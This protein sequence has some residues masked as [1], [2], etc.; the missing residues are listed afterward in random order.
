M[1]ENGEKKLGIR[2]PVS[3]GSRIQQ[4]YGGLYDA[5]KRAKMYDQMKH[6]M[7][8]RKFL[9]NTF[10]IFILLGTLFAFW[11][12]YKAWDAHLEHKRELAAAEQAANDA[13]EAENARLRREEQERERARVEAE[14]AAQREE[15]ERK[16]QERRLA[17][18][19]RRETI[20]SYKVFSY[21][22]R[23][24]E[25][26]MYAKSVTNI[27]SEAKGELCY[28]L[29]DKEPV[30]YWATSNTNGETM[31]LRINE[32]GDREPLDASSFFARVSKFDYLVAG[33]GKVYYH[34]NRKNPVWGHLSKTQ[35]R[36]PAKVFFAGLS[37]RLET[38]KPAYDE[39]TF[40]IVFI[41][42][43]SKKQIVCETLEFGCAYSLDNVREAVVQAFPPRGYVGSSF[44]VKKFKRTAKLWDGPDIKQGVDGITYVPRTMPST[45]YDSFYSDHVL[46]SRVIHRRYARRQLSVDRWQ[47][48]YD[49][50]VKE[51]EAEAEY[52]RRQKEDFDSR[53]Q[54]SLSD[55]ERAYV[56]RIDR[57]IDEG[58]LYYHAKKRKAK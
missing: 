13:R 18:Q 3:Q 25:L 57:I 44:N 19:E 38:L 34:A 29:P 52:Y 33:E 2:R 47:S 17:E 24:N 14:R 39:I 15:K 11:F 1:T 8:I 16:E 49:K 55:S 9:K 22:L 26:C 30:F 42:K 56:N 23:E 5:E 12:I 4:E 6:R 37:E 48:L 46:A 28:L 20:E 54:K 45:S 50:A 10:E 36:D 7:W 53:R 41:P 58:E 51:E 31:V 21:A 27:L 40:D 32:K 35:S 43:G